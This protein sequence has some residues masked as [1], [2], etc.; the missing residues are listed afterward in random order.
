[1]AYQ[2]I[3]RGSAAN[4]GTGDDLRTG[5][6]K[7]NANFV[8]IYT[9]LGNG[10]A[11]SADDFA[12]FTGTETLTNK[13]L[14]DPEIDGS[15]GIK[16]GSSANLK[17]SAGNQ[18]VEI[19]GGGSNSG[20][21]TLNCESNS[22]GQKLLGQPHSAGVTNIQL[23]PAGADS[24]LVSRVSTDTLTNKSISGGTNTITALPNSALTNSQITLGSTGMALGAT[25]TTIAG[26]TSLTSA[27][28]TDGTMTINGGNISAAGTI[29]ATTVTA[30][31]V[32]GYYKIAQWKT[33]VAGSADFAAFK[34]AV[35]AL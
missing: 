1:M 23:L 6:G 33:L 7:L 5:A 32:T 21:I 29:A 22:H 14:T 15:S 18:I 34:T 26:M 2:P 9:K 28:I 20:S 27:T 30:T 13:T 35:A 3:G 16:S 12:T 4:D 8:E 25:V 24:T 11:L 17:I 19:R 10:S 31:T